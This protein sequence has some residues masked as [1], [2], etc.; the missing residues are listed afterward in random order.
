MSEMVGYYIEARG[1]KNVD[2]LEEFRELAK[3]FQNAELYEYQDKNDSI[4]ER[5]IGVEVPQGWHGGSSCKEILQEYFGEWLK[6]HPHIE[7][8]A[9]VEYLEYCPKEEFDGDEIRELEEVRKIEK[10]AGIL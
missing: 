8:K 5:V 4:E 9:T 3:N 2:E 7:F 1:F 6:K 10:E